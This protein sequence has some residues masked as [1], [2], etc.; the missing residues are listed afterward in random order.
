MRLTASR[1]KPALKPATSDVEESLPSDP[2][3]LKPMT[4]N[5]PATAAAV[6]RLSSRSENKIQMATCSLWRVL[7]CLA[8]PPCSQGWWRM[9][10]RLIVPDLAVFTKSPPALSR[11]STFF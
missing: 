6:D 8:I 3:E 2:R 10:P 4:V 1:R 5:P 7:D 11:C 9:G